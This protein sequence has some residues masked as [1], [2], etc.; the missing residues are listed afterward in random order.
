[1][2]DR[3][4]ESP[5][6]AIPGAQVEVLGGS[7]VAAA[8]LLPRSASGS[9]RLS[10]VAR[11]ARNLTGRI[12]LVAPR[13][14]GPTTKYA[15][16]DIDPIEPVSDEDPAAPGTV[17]LARLRSEVRH[18]AQQVQA[19]ATEVDRF[20]RLLT[21]EC[22]QSGTRGLD[23]EAIYVIREQQM[24]HFLS[25]MVHALQTLLQQRAATPPP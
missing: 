25:S 16:T 13:P 11:C 8:L 19:L 14:P 22:V 5:P 2:A 21:A 15:M 24:T 6:H 4:A 17:E 12:A 1:M 10:P 23:R 9:I 7:C 3:A 18:L 20:R